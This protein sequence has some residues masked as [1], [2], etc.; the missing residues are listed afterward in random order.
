M[1]E[2]IPDLHRVTVGGDKGVYNTK[3]MVR[4]FRASNATLH[5]AKNV[6]AWRSSTT[7]ER[8]T[9]HKGY[10]MSQKKHKR[11]EE[12]FG[13]LKTVG[14]IRTVRHKGESR[15][16]WTFTFASAA[17]NLVRTRNLEAIAGNE[18]ARIAGAD[19]A[20][21]NDWRALSPRPSAPWRVV[22]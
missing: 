16:G 22:R 15:V 19:R 21:P 6:T 11:A 5:V 8:T 4:E 17:Y 13:W 7:D 2:Q 10:A 12:I 9:Q 1:V 14:L 20:P 3:E 18:C